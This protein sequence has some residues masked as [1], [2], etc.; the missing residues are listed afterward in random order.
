MTSIT[1]FSSSIESPIGP[2]FVVATQDGLLKIALSNEDPAD[3]EEALSTL[4]GSSVATAGGELSDVA[5]QFEEY[6]TG[7][8][9][10]FTLPLD[11]SLSVGLGKAVHRQ[12]STIPYGE[13]TSYKAIAIDIG[14]PDAVRAVGT[15][16]G[17]N[18]LPVI[19]PCHRVLRND[20]GLGGYAGGLD[21]K[22]TLLKI[23]AD[24]VG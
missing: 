21:R 16:C 6:F 1:L 24:F 2:L 10:E 23:E 20:G 8:R 9:K 18:P 14:S 13:T 17:A 15:A 5:L 3:V 7:I 4:Y 22:K 12:I 11:R 19:V